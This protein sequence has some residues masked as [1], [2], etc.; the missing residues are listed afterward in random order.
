VESLAKFCGP[1]GEIP[2]LTV[3]KSS[4]FHGLPWPPI[5]AVHK[6]QLLKAGSIALSYVSNRKIKSFF[7]LFKSAMKLMTHE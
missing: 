5:Y 2:Q 1:I 7:F 3:P 4:K 6:L